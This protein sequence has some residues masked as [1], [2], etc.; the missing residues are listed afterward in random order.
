[1]TEIRPI[2]DAGPAL[3]FFAANKERILFATLGT[4]VY[5][6][7]VVDAEIRRK[8]RED[9]FCAAEKV[10]N[11]LPTRLYDTLSDDPSPELTAAVAR[12]SELPYEDRV[13]R[14]K[15]LGE[16]MAIAHAVVLAEAG[17]N[18]TVM[19]DDGGGRK[20]AG[21]EIRRL[22]RRRTGGFPD[23][24]SISLTSTL[25]VLEQAGRLRVIRDRGTMREVYSQIRVMES[26]LGDIS[27]TRLLSGEIW[28]LP[29][30]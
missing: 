6:P 12:I 25:G 15:D 21:K 20:L 2:I 9:R 19:L 16:V 23:C 5:A 30:P 7:E 14:S 18:V 17:A 4:G 10:L 27:T 24:G 13:G 11:R 8:A 29:T 22:H 3:D 1:M 28:D 26:G